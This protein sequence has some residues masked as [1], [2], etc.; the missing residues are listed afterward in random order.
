MDIFKNFRRNSA[1]ERLNEEKLYELVVKEMRA[2][3]IREGLMAKALSENS[4]NEELANAAYI[5]MRVQSI[6][7]E[8]EVET[9]IMEGIINEQIKQEEEK[10]IEEENKFNSTIANNKIPEGDPPKTSD[11]MKILGGLVTLSILSF[12]LLFIFSSI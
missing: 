6:I 3:I 11:L 5:K 9:S 10:Q 1:L 2:Q 7:D 12:L 8:N 4:G